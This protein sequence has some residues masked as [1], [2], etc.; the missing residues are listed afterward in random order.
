MFLKVPQQTDCTSCGILSLRNV[1]EFLNAKRLERETKIPW[2]NSLKDYSVDVSDINKMRE[3][4]V[5]RIATLTQNKEEFLEE[6]RSR[7]GLNTTVSSLPDTSK[8][9]TLPI[10]KSGYKP[11]EKLDQVS[12]CFENIF[13]SG[14]DMKKAAFVFNN[15]V[16]S[17]Q[18]IVLIRYGIPPEN[19]IQKSSKF[20]GFYRIDDN[21]YD[22][23]MPAYKKL[24]IPYI[25]YAQVS[26]DAVI[27]NGKVFI[28][29]TFL[30]EETNP[31]NKFLMLVSVGMTACAQPARR[32]WVYD[33]RV[34]DHMSFS[35][36]QDSDIKAYTC[37]LTNKY[38]AEFLEMVRFKFY[39]F[40]MNTRRLYDP[41]RGRRFES[42]TYIKSD[43]SMH[44]ADRFVD[45]FDESLGLWYGKMLP[46][47][48][49]QVQ[50]IYR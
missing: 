45:D 47:S 42:K 18:S 39:Q 49:E 38:D 33:T 24:A 31:N 25:I 17:K 46:D 4:F 43:K 10:V 50:A 40:L 36:W 7:R 26:L 19:L 9:H 5:E 11:F 13:T 3:S 37:D 8:S 15:P 6:L 21:H 35:E 48:Y 29:Q 28:S 22:D 23:K 16:H 27:Y 41:T 12:F 44:P 32:Y 2:Y 30:V 1:A 20:Q 34:E 14:K